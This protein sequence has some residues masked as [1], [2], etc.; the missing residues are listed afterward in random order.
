M[1]HE[2]CVFI[3]EGYQAVHSAVFTHHST[4]AEIRVKWKCP[5]K[6]LQ[7]DH[8]GQFWGILDELFTLTWIL[9]DLFTLTVWWFNP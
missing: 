5:P 6:L 2:W 4:R 1:Y 8:C 7:N 3:H 9:D